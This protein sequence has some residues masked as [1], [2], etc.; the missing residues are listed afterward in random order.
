LKNLPDFTQAIWQRQRNDA[1]LAVTIRD[2]K[3]TGMPA[4]GDRLSKA[5]IKTLVAQLRS[6]APEHNR[7]P[8]SGSPPSSV[9]T[10]FDTRFQQLLNE[11][12]EL[13]M[14][15]R[16]LTAAEGS[17]AKPPARRAARQDDDDPEEPAPTA[18]EHFAELCQRCHGA[19]GKGRQGKNDNLPDFTRRAWQARR[20]DAQLLASILNGTKG[21]MPPFRQR[22][23]EAQAKELVAHIRRFCPA[24]PNKSGS[25]PSTSG[26]QS[27]SSMERKHDCTD[28]G[29]LGHPR[30]KGPHVRG[31]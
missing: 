28:A 26:D 8:A 5:Q 13:K 10:D 30:G 17:R 12:E 14:Q 1:Q 15:M 21:G 19:D 11:L 29:L 23:S 4:F 25:P 16:Q 2:G 3:G 9:E 24:R 7:M 31:C 20:T 18:A 6:F 22:L 27:A